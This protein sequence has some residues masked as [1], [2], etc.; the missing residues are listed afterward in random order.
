[1][2]AYHRFETD[3]R[4]LPVLWHQCFLTF[5][6]RYKTDVS[7]DQKEALLKLLKVHFH[8]QITDQI[9]YEYNN[10]TC[11]ESEFAPMQTM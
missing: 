2:H 10:S 1:M 11:R 6:Q 8:P 7:E 4:K 9:R 5:A 3:Q